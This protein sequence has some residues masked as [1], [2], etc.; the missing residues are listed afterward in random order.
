MKR[1]A[2]I[3]L[4]LFAA[5]FPAFAQNTADLI[6]LNDATPAIDVVITLP[7]DTTGTISLDVALASVTLKDASNNIVFYAADERLHGLEFNIAP[8]SGSH[9]LTI[10]RLA[11]V[12]EAYVSVSSLPEMTM[13]GTVELIPGNL[14]TLNQEVSLALDATNPGNTTMVNIPEDTTGVVTATFP[15]AYATTQLLDDTGLVVAQSVGG[16]LDGLT[17]LLD[18][19]EYEFTLLG[20]SLT[21]TVIAGVRAV[22]ADDAGFMILEAPEQVV[23]TT[24][25]TGVSCTA[26]VGM[27][28]VNLR[29]GPGT[30]YSVLDYGYRGETFAVGGRNPENNWI[31]VGMSNG[32]S[33]WMAANTALLQG[34]C[35]ALTVF[36]IPLQDAVPAQI[37]ITS[38]VTGSYD[39]DDDHEEYEY[40]HEDDDDDDHEEHDDD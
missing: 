17:F 13:N 3:F 15:G 23:S 2:F 12:T 25:D 30:G 34:D 29:S 38:P 6:T 26:T 19:G 21:D 8:N 7:R 11:G 22:S 37:V 39:D 10:E 20:S 1:L 40:E 27:S 35:G 5:S 36:N 24:V 16:H 32:D 4:A 31:V 28:S 14:V 33:A 18:G 9:T